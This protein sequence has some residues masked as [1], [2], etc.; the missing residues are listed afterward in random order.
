MTRFTFGGGAADF[1][2][3]EHMVGG[4]D[5]VTLA[6]A[7][8]TFWSTQTG[9]TNYTDLVLNGVSVSSITASSS[10]G[11]PSFQ[12][13]DGVSSMWADGGAGRV[14]MYAYDAYADTTD[15]AVATAVEDPASATTAALSATYAPVVEVSRR[16]ASEAAPWTPLLLPSLIGWY[17]AGSLSGANGSAVATWPDLSGNGMDMVSPSW[18]V[19]IS[20]SPAF[21]S[22]TL[23][24][25]SQ[26][27]QPVVRFDGNG[28]VLQSVLTP[29]LNSGPTSVPT[30]VGPMTVFMAARATLPWPNTYTS[31]TG[32]SGILLH[33]SGAGS[34]IAKNSG[35]TAGVYANYQDDAGSAR[36]LGGSLPP[37]EGLMQTITAIWDGTSSGS[38]TPS[39]PASGSYTVNNTDSPVAVYLSGGTIS[40]ISV[41]SSYGGSTPASNVFALPAT[42]PVVILAP[43][44]G[45]A[46]TYTVAPTWTWVPSG[47]MRAGMTLRVNGYEMN[48]VSCRQPKPT[49]ITLGAVP[50]SHGGTSS[51]Y[52]GYQA[53]DIAEIIILNKAATDAEINLVERYLTR[54]A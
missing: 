1:T 11:I 49:A 48:D 31:D 8:I 10:G 40:A 50:P 23:V 29:L 17:D 26:N 27:A 18:N 44:Q 15:A 5:Y 38:R 32:L 3:A 39:V 21:T 54:G 37:V 46:V 4:Q 35:G 42:T 30:L 43:Y 34:V 51:S 28:N 33:L 12:G 14:R 6:P 25:G 19:P 41:S 45:I 20:Q 16:A 22:P 13:P 24:N 2:F 9:G 36:A 47:P 52:G 7:T 53:C